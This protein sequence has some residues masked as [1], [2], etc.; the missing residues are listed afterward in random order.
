MFLQRGLR[1]MPATADAADLPPSPP[2]QVVASVGVGRR[3]QQVDRG[4]I[5]Q[6]TRDAG[7]GSPGRFGDSDAIGGRGQGGDGGSI[8]RRRRQSFSGRSARESTT[9]PPVSV[10]KTQVACTASVGGRGS[11]SIPF[12]SIALQP[13]A[14][15]GTPPR[16]SERVDQHAA[17]VNGHS[18]RADERASRRPRS[19]P[20]RVYSHNELEWL[21]KNVD[22]AAQSLDE[23]LARWV[24]K[25]L[26]SARVEHPFSIA[27]R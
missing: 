23:R 8:R 26:P 22:E 25:P 13:V 15:S 12:P 2:T 11:N 7:S 16:S 14:R 21:G 3:R 4:G 20:R 5:R 17:T 18:T 19:A 27:P 6:A 1:A 24:L 9:P 10:S